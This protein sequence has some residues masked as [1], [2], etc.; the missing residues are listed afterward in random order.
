MSLRLELDQ[1]LEERFRKAAMN[2]YGY[3]KGSLKKAAEEAFYLWINTSKT[4]SI[5]KVDDPV[6][7]IKGLFAPLKGKYTSVQL[8]HESGKLWLKK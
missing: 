4:T 2:T 1:K 5:K 6:K 7:L 8:Q 3:E